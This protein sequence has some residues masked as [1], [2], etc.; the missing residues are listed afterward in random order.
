MATTNDQNKGGQGNTETPKGDQGATGD[1][2]DKSKTG[3]QGTGGETKTGDEGKGGEAVKDPAAQGDGTQSKKD[4]QGKGGKT[5]DEKK[6]APDKYELKVPENS[7][8]D[9]DDLKL[10]EQLARENDWDNETAQAAV[11][12]HHDMLAEQSS[13]FLEATKADKDYGGD[14]LSATQQRAKAV[15]DMVRPA[16]H[17]R[18]KA[19]RALLDKSGYG[20]HIEVISFL[21]DLGKMTEEDGAISGAGGGGGE[22]DAAAVLYDGNSKN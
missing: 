14:K 19:F 13:K 12:Q 15:I 8:V 21:A 6:G 11:Q 16:S 1:T 9:A 22:K 7:S 18:A 4:D 5:G 17:P 10:I 2:T 3:E 20:N